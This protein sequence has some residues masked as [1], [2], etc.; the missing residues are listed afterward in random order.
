MKILIVD[1]NPDFCS[2]IAD[3][4]GSFG[5]DAHIINSPEETL[6]FLSK[7]HSK[8][9]VILLDIEFGPNT[10]MNG[11][12]VLGYCRLHYPSIPVVMI[13]GR[14]TIET[15][16]K[17][18]KLGALNFIEKS[19]I[20]KEKLREVLNSAVEKIGSEGEA[21]EIQNFLKHHGIIGKTKIMLEIGDSIFR[22]GK[23]DLNVLISGETGT[24]K[25]LVA[26]AIHAIS[27]RNKNAF[28]TVDIPNI[29]RELFQSELFGYN[30][31][32]FTGAND[33][34][35]GLFHQANKGTLFLDEIGDLSLDLQSSLFIPI[36]E[37]SVRRL[38]S[39]ESEDLDVRFISATD[40]DLLYAMKESKFREQLYHR[41]RECEIHIPPLK[42][43]KEDIPDIVD[44]FIQNHNEEF[45]EAKLFSP[46]A[47]EFLLEYDWPGNVRELSSIIKVALQTATNNQI[48]ISSL[49]KI[50]ST[51][52]QT[53]KS[54]LSQENFLSQSGTLK[55]DLALLDKKKIETTLEKCNGNVSK[56]AAM[57]GISRETL[58]NKIRKYEINT[59]SFRG[60]KV[61]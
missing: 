42:E 56:S 59:Q 5:Y 37:K 36:E 33:T 20:S 41:L 38:G 12:D 28:V 1:D 49:H 16:V 3:I 9:S 13:S 44:F 61:K 21:R 6:D 24:G 7:F 39:A 53:N 10:K 26:K 25:R 47:I 8:I 55:E 30:K 23:T 48:E 4:V 58:H 51:S 60:K 18:T 14:G 19:I 22:F 35:K 50:L 32:S 43:R 2:T 57:L 40:K 45:N 11:I 46:S 27:R 15:A 29:P 34:K 52:S 54:A 31:G 17:A